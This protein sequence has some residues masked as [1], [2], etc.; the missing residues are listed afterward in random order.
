MN[1]LHLT[2]WNGHLTTE[3]QARIALD[4]KHQDE[5]KQAYL[6][7][8]DVRDRA[9]LATCQLETIHQLVRQNRAIRIAMRHRHR[10]ENEALNQK[11]A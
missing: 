11:L 6:N 8:I 3:V 4:D 2:E 9:I 5:H 7:E 1:L 10:Q